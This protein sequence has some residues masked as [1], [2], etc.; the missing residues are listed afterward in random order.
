MCA[1]T[2]TYNYNGTCVH[3]LC[4]PLSRSC[5]F[6]THFG[7]SFKTF[8]SYV[9]QC[10][11]VKIGPIYPF[12][13]FTCPQPPP[14]QTVLFCSYLCMY[15]LTTISIS[16]SANVREQVTT[17]VVHM[18][19]CMCVYLST[20]CLKDYHTMC[21]YHWMEIDAQWHIETSPIALYFQTVVQEIKSLNNIYFRNELPIAS[22]YRSFIIRG[23]N[24]MLI[25]FRL[26][27][28][29]TVTEGLPNPLGN[30]R[31]IIF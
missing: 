8:W 10:P 21:H 16:P 25:N 23:L 13:P 22:L 29:W 4:Y 15:A 28:I 20:I 5:N 24:Y 14:L 31:Y 3:V 27:G 9:A 19:V 12:V 30:W 1:H 26:L 11:D 18:Y 7:C 2:H 6:V 17:I